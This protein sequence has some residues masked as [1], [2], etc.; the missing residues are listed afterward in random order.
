MFGGRLAR[1]YA[2]KQSACGS[3]GEKG[4]SRSMLVHVPGR[5]AKLALRRRN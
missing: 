4:V 3:F 5:N 1:N 2:M